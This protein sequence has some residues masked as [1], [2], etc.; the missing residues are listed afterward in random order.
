MAIMVLQMSGCVV[1][2]DYPESQI[3]EGVI[4]SHEGKPV[5][6]A[7]ITIWEGRKF[8]TLFPISYPDAARGESDE[9]GRFSIPVKN[10][11]PAR[12]TAYTRC[13]SGHSEAAEGSL[14]EVVVKMEPRQG[15]CQL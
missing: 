4:L 11:W 8:L 5:E 2:L 7:H 1:Y 10:V 6:G 15:A 3:V 14:K 12:I 13:E 9:M